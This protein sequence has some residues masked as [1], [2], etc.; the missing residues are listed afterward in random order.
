[1]APPAQD[2]VGAVVAR[3]ATLVVI[4]PSGNRTRTSLSPLPY[5][6]GRQADNHL[7]LRDNRASRN[8]ARIVTENGD[9]FIEDLKS[10]HG[11]YVN[12][13]RVTRQKLYHSDRIEFGFQDSYTLVF[14][15]EEDEIQK[16]LNSL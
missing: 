1:M 9:Y 7:I 10:S 15:L 13:A 14:S 4:N 5:T 8:H 3:P 11:V 12:G 6:I 16:L 2:P